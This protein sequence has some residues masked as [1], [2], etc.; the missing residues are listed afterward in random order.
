MDKIITNFSLETELA[1]LFAGTAVMLE[2]CYLEGSGRRMLGILDAAPGFISIESVDVKSTRIGR[3][4]PVWHAYAF[5][6]LELAGFDASRWRLADSALERLNDLLGLL[7]SGD[8]YFEDCLQTAGVDDPLQTRGHLAELLKRV[9]ARL[10]LDSGQP[11][12]VEELAALA[13]MSDRSVRNALSAEGGARLQADDSGRVSN[14][15]ALRWLAGRRNFKPTQRRVMP[16]QLATMTD[17]L[18][19]AEIPRFVE[20]RLHQLSATWGDYHAQF[21]GVPNPLAHEAARRSGLVPARI[22]AAVTL[23]LTIKPEECLP[24]ARV[25]EVEPAWFTYQVM[26]ALFPDQ[27]DMLLNP[28]SWAAP[29][30]AAACGADAP[31]SV[32]VELTE[33]MLKH[34]YLDI[35]I[36]AKDL[37][38]DSDFGSKGTG[39]EGT[40]VDIVFGSHRATTDIRM[41]S[42]KTLA[43]RKRFNAWFNT[44][45]RAKPGDRIRL[46]KVSDS[47]FTL[48]FL[49]T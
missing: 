23:P 5:D 3:M 27:I 31:N 28:G 18:F 10:S 38:P 49:P 37:F 4:L 15:E 25:L 30:T 17:M 16:D 21:H 1:G 20:T 44:E 33:S 43:P 6:G 13:E 45:L 32:I 29:E 24:L 39:F 46:D 7:R 2:D 12:S 41:K 19:A 9:Q 8:A 22:E 35:P 47:E 34:G 11:V 14:E 26:V 48:T 36:S 40:P 42:S